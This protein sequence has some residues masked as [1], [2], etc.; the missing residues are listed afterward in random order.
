MREAVVVSVAVLIVLVIAVAATLIWQSRLGG[1]SSRAAAARGPRHGGAWNAGTG[2]DAGVYY[3]AGN[4]NWDATGGAWGGGGTWGSGDSC[5]DGGWNGAG[6]SGGCSDSGG[7]G[8]C[9]GG[10][11]GGGGD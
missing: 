10:G 11:C 9:G 7:G 4:T 1:R 8:G 2:A 5:G 3:A 6:D